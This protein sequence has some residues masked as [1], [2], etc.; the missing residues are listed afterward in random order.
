LWRDPGGKSTVISRSLSRVDNE[1]YSSSSGS[2]SI[3]GEPTD[4]KIGGE[5]KV[6]LL[7]LGENGMMTLDGTCTGTVFYPEPEDDKL[8]YKE[9][10]VDLAVPTKLHIAEKYRYQSPPNPYPRVALLAFGICV[11]FGLGAVY[12][13]GTSLNAIVQLT[14]EEVLHHICC[15]GLWSQREEAEKRLS[16][17]SIK[18]PR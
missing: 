16:E 11:V 18:R 3:T 2:I 5:F 8:A 4:L 14:D 12:S 13:W 10:R 6:P 1:R 17:L 7:S 15:F 9:R